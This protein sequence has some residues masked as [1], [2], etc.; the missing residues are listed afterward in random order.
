MRIHLLLKMSTYVYS[1]VWNVKD[2]RRRTILGDKSKQRRV[3]G[4]VRK[5][6]LCV[7]SPI[8][9]APVLVPLDGVESVVAQVVVAGQPRLAVHSLVP[10]NLHRRHLNG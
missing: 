8:E 5:S 7:S 3:V 6:F 10:G 9:L 2:L 4:N 1:D